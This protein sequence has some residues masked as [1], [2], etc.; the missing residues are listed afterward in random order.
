MLRYRLEVQYDGSHFSG[1]Q[2]QKNKK[3]VQG[4]LEDV[5]SVLSKTESRVPVHGS[6]RTDTGVHAFRQIAH[7]D[8]NIK[9]KCDELR[10]ALNG[11]LPY[12]CRINKIEIVDSLFH[13]RFDA[14]RRFYKYQCYIGKSILYRNQAWMLNELDVTFLNSLSKNILGENNFLS[15]SKYRKD[16]NSICKIFNCEWAS[17]G[18]MVTF[19]IE[20]NRFLHHM[21]RYL[22]GTMVAV[23][24]NKI[25]EGHFLNLLANPRKNV[26]IFKAPAQGLILDKILYEE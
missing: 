15:F 3:T 2:L 23:S 17:D 11:N 12:Y 6:G 22:V 24:K 7:V 14:K 18:E 4:M 1:W 26:K 5:M 9:Y 20:A 8:L 19:H 25:T 16:K 10:N 21:I 13:S